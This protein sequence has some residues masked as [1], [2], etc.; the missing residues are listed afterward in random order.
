MPHL[1]FCFIALIF[2]QAHCHSAKLHILTDDKNSVFDFVSKY[3]PKKP[4][5]IEAGA[6]NGKDSLKMMKRWPKA[7]LYA[8]EPVPEIFSLLIKNTKGVKNISCFRLALSDFTGK[9]VLYTESS[10]H[11]TGSGSLLPPK[12]HTIHSDI[13]FSGTIE[14]DAITLDDWAS[15]NGIAHIDFMWL[16]MQGYELNMLKCS[17]IALTAKAIYTEMEFVEAYKGQYLYK[18]VVEWMEANGFI[19]AAIDFDPEQPFKKIPKTKLEGKFWYGNGVF[20]NK[21]YFDLD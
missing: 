3:L 16:D 6:F 19:L 4:I 13:H 21:R 9:M 7:R 14:V 11:C 5:I 17:K 12:E 10:E 18:D 15:Q 2:F 1:I 20:L 8:F